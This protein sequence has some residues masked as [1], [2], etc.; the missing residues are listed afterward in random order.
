M[1]IVTRGTAKDP[2]GMAS[3]LPGVGNV[4][5]PGVGNLPGI[6]NLLPGQGSGQSGGGQQQQPRSPIPGVPLPLPNIF[7]R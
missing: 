6:G 1:L 3:T 4:P 7:G 5:V 2:P